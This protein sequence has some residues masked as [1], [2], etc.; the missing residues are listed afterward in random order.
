M[1]LNKVLNLE[2]IFSLTFLSFDAQGGPGEKG[3][4][5][6]AGAPGF[7]VWLNYD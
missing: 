7:Q 3:E 4:Q 5:G 6:P 2:V 1:D